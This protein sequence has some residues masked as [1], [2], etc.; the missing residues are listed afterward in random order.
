MNLVRTDIFEAALSLP[1][2]DR[3]SLADKLLDSLNPVDS[4]VEKAW[5]NEVERRIKSFDD[6]ETLAIEGEEVFKEFLG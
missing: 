1:S 2:G 6:G 5:I 4:Q 3:A